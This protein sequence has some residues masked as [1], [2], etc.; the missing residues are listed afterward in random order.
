MASVIRG[1]DN[2]DTETGIAGFV[3]AHIDQSG[4]QALKDSKGVSSIT[5]T[6][7]GR[8]KT[9][10]SNAYANVYYSASAIQSNTAS[11]TSQISIYG[12][13]SA[14]YV[15]IDMTT[16]TI[17]TA[18]NADRKVHALQFIGDLG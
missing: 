17:E 6:A 7:G 5:D 10:F 4:T 18:S 3:W 16:T 13:S 2:F 14:P 12:S 11:G 8:T 9:T 1:D 15:P